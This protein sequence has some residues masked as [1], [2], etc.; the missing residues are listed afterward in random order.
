MTYSALSVWSQMVQHYA[1]SRISKSSTVAAAI[2][3]SDDVMTILFH[4]FKMNI[5]KNQSLSNT[6]ISTHIENRT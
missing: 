2:A 4:S 1:T 3:A 6:K 5:R